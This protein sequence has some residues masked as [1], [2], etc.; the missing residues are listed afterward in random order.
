MYII[1]PVS[2]WWVLLPRATDLST[3]LTRSELLVVDFMLVVV[4]VVI[5]VVVVVVMF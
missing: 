5:V 3:I 4:M 1:H 2:L